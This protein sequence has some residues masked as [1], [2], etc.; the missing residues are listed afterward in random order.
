MDNDALL[1]A[2]DAAEEESYGQESGDE[3]SA[4]RA[5]ALSAYLGENVDP[6]PEGRSQVVDRTLFETVESILPSLVRIFASGDDVCK[7]LPVG[8]DD[9]EAAEQTTALL[10][11]TVTEK[12]QWEQIAHDWFKDALLLKNGYCLAYWDSSKRV[13]QETYEGQSDEQLAMLMQDEEIRVV[14]HSERPDDETNERNAQQYQQAMQ[15][16]Q[17]QAQQAQMQAQQTGQ[18]PQM[19][20]PPQ[21]PQPAMLHDLVIE[22]TESEGKPCIKVL[23]PEHCRVAWS[24]PDFTLKDCPYFEFWDLR[25][26]SELRSMGLKVED[27]INDNDDDDTL[28]DEARDRYGEDREDEGVDPS[29][30][31][32]K[33]RM[34]WIK[35][36]LEGDGV[37]RMYYCIRVGQEILYVEPVSRIPVASITP[38]PLP[39]RHIGL[40]MWDILEDV[41]Q[42]KQ[43]VIRSALDNLYLSVNGRNIVSDQVNLDDLLTVRP[44]G[45]VRMQPG[46]IPGEG[47]VLP[48]THPFAFDQ[49]ISSLA[50]FDQQKQNI[51]GVNSYF[52]GVDQNAINRTASGLAMMTTQSAQRVEQVA[53]MFATGVEYL[54]NCVLELI[55]KHSN[56][57]QIFNLR[58]KWFAVHPLAWSKKRDL[59]ISVGV[60][61]GNKDAMLAQLQQMFGAQTQ[62]GMAIGI[63]DPQTVYNTASEIAKLQGFAQPERFWVDPAQR[64]PPQPQ[65]PPEIVKTQMQIQ[66]DQQAK[67]VDAQLE[68]QKLTTD[69]SLKKYEIDKTDERERWKVVYQAQVDAGLKQMD[70]QTSA[71]IELRRIMSSEGIEDKRLS[72]KD[73]DMA[74]KRALEALMQQV[75]MLQQGLQQVISMQDGKRVVGVEKV[76]GP[77]GRMVAGRVKRAD[78]ST[79]EIT[80]Q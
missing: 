53:R 34:V 12:N 17:M 21:P 33:T 49:I 50:Y 54:F 35:T 20:P 41:Q 10:Q 59:K 11:W 22:R 72:R 48:L 38:L 15:Q 9:H 67:Q 73:E 2:I 62:I 27:D 74:E 56:K 29:M 40:G 79:E 6:A 57:E 46:A 24:T 52:N 30:R 55:Q 80:I 31:R 25:T 64:P 13:L 36:D 32:V 42:T 77:D 70:A 19:P 5:A 68:N 65:P 7:V 45:I 51:S 43:A 66:A 61:A 8:P 75:Q 3:L 28:E 63:A 47:H 37:A 1:R 69:A 14:Q 58:G 39:H 71:D 60:G 26:I 44:G 18:P 4:A 23:P 78:G 76:R 16:Y